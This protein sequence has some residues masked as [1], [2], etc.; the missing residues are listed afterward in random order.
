VSMTLKA[1]FISRYSDI[2]ESGC[3]RGG[4]GRFLN[5]IRMFLK[6]VP[7]VFKPSSTAGSNGRRLPAAMALRPRLISIHHGQIVHA[8]S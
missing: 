6:V 8:V 5:Y 2:S 1:G 7:P 4:I 3:L